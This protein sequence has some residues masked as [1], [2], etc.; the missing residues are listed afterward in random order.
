M[1]YAGSYEAASQEMSADAPATDL[2]AAASDEVCERVL[3]PV[4]GGPE[5]DR[6]VQV[7]TA[8]AGAR[9][10][11]LVFAAPVVNPTQLPMGRVPEARL[12]S[13]REAV[14]A[15]AGEVREETGL[16]AESVVRIGR[17]RCGTVAATA[18][19][20]GASTVV[21]HE[22]GELGSS[23][24]VPSTADAVAGKT[25]CDVVSVTGEPPV[26]SV[27]SVLLA[28]AGGPDSGLAAA[29]ARD[30]AVASD[31]WVDVFHVCPP[32]AG[33]RRRARARQFVSAARD[34]LAG[35]ENHDV[36]IRETADVV[37]ALVEQSTYYD[38]TVMGAPRK[39]RLGR[40]FSGSTAEDVRQDAR[41]AVVTVR[42]GSD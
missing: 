14:R 3:V 37:E 27:A 41:N 6:A 25:D 11:E 15:V 4:T 7:A 19:E 21:L 38:V 31:A 26:G 16:A 24:I 12:E 40:F 42:S 9:S 35:Y 5:H 1:T 13:R 30:V 8:V 18:D 32:D 10:A 36:W 28:V 34:R 29:V 39:G 23:P 20:Y 2:G 33:R 17:D 22:D